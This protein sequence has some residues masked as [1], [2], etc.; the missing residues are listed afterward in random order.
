[1]YLFINILIIDKIFLKKI[2]TL[3]NSI[4]IIIIFIISLIFIQ[5]NGELNM[6]I[7]LLSTDIVY[8]LIISIS[9]SL[10]IMHIKFN[11]KDRYAIF[12]IIGIILLSLSRPA[13]RYLI[14]LFPFIYMLIFKD[15]YSINFRYYIN[16]IVFIFFNILILTKQYIHGT[17]CVDAINY[18]N[19]NSVIDETLPG[20][21]LGSYGN[22]FSNNNKNKKYI[23]KKNI[24]EEN[25]KTIFKK[26]KEIRGYVQKISIETL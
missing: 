5:N 13:D 21:C 18:L 9:A 11:Q 3:K 2:T 8:K 23:I 10:G 26:E 4:T 20:D 22:L 12:V 14:F 6:P 24:A 19:N 1:M 16:I 7:K 17:L 25:N 15:N